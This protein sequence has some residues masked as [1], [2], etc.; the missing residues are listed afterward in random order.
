MWR[1]PERLGLMMI[2]LPMVVYALCGCGC[3]LDRSPGGEG[4][5]VVMTYN[6]QNL[7]DPYSDGTEYPEY[8]PQGGWTGEGYLLRLERVSRAILQTGAMLP[9]VVVMQEIEHDKVLTTLL[10]QYLAK[11]GFQWYAATADPDSAIQTGVISRL[12]IVSARVHGVPGCRSVLEVTIDADGS[13]V[14]V[15]AVHAKSRSEGVAETEGQR[16]ALTRVLRTVV[17][18]L[19]AVDPFVEVLIAGDFNE[20]ADAYLREGSLAQTALV[21]A[22][23]V[24]AQ[25]YAAQGSLLLSGSQPA[26]GTWYSWWLD[27]SSGITA[28]LDGSYW[29][30]GVWETFDQILLA[31][32]FFDGEGWDYEKGQVDAQH[33]LCDVSG[34]PFAWNILLKEGFSDHLPVYMVLRRPNP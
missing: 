26:A 19:F 5:L 34:Y 12:P 30:R 20:S 25:D 27:R 3:E 24:G 21:P 1:I 13:P 28:N 29:F 11:R 15:L 16:I 8:T 14:V 4:R 9:D 33:M 22:G 7:F 32:G 18:E 31:P 2:V 10:E 6:V 17:D 23:A